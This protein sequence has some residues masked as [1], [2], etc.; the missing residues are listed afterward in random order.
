M[1]LDCYFRRENNHLYDIVNEYANNV[2]AL[3]VVP[4][5]DYFRFVFL[6]YL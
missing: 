3:T 5:W 1:S 4:F 6:Q 2:S